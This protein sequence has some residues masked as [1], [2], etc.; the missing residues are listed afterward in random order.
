MTKDEKSFAR[1]KKSA[2][3]NLAMLMERFNMEVV[4]HSFTDAKVKMDGVAI[5]DVPEKAGMKKTVAA[6]REAARAENN[7][8]N[9]VTR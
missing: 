1:R 4:T 2:L 7:V 5:F 9:R 8:I 6:M 3:L